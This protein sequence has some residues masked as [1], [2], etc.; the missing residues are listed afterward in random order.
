ML[1]VLAEVTDTDPATSVETAE[2]LLDSLGPGPGP[3]PGLSA[4]VLLHGED[5]GAWPVLRLAAQLGLDMRIGLEDVLV[6][7]D[8]SVPAGNAALVRA[9][10]AVVR[11]GRGPGA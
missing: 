11:A 4:P 7:P 9:A 10:R 6:L 1:R 2:S 8:G 5:G 3:G